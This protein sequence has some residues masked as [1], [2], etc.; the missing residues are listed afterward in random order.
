M[1]KISLKTLVQEELKKPAGKLTAG[2]QPIVQK[3]EEVKIVEN[4]NPK[5]RSGLKS[6]LEVNTDMQPTVKKNQLN[7]LV[8]TPVIQIQEQKE[9]IVIKVSEPVVEKVIVSKPVVEAAEIKIIKE[10]TLIDKASA[11]ISSR[12]KNEDSYQ[13]PVA[14]TPANFS[15]V[16]RKVK[17][18][19]E[20]I[21]KVSMSGP[22]SGEV[23]LLRLDDVNYQSWQNRDEHKILKFS[24]NANPAFD[25][26]TFG[27]LTGD[28]GEIF[29][30]KYNPYTGYTS[31]ANVAPGLTYY[32]PERDTLEVLHKDG[33]ATYVGQDNFIRFKNGNANTIQ[34]GSLVRF[35]GSDFV[36]NVPLCDLYVSDITSTPLYIT[37]VSVTDCEPDTLGRAMLLGE[38]EDFNASGSAVGEN[39][40]IGDLLWASPTVPGQLT[41]IR[42][43]SPNVVVSIAAVMNNSST[44][45][46]ILVRPTI[47]PR[48]LSGDFYSTQIQTAPNINFAHQITFSNTLFT[49]GVTRTGNVIT[50]SEAGLYK[51]DLRLQ[52]S[53]TNS[54][55]KSL[56]AWF[57]KDNVNVP[58]S[59]VRQSVAT[60]GGY[61]VLTNTQTISL[62][63]TDNVTMFYAVTSTSLFIDSPN[64]IDD[65]A[66]IPS[67]QLTVTQPAL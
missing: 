14:V 27:F 3:T 28:Q 43:T 13:Q 4:F 42:P 34:K 7:E 32:D 41:N 31:N 17:F 33:S 30:L 52:L 66:S 26:V 5:P 53:S 47:W 61:S 46:R 12:T 65:S 49:S 23:R 64:I 19:E 59:S 10:E 62:T 50:V 24:P 6:L 20:W 51:F 45:G 44:T 54:N 38:V 25:G 9:S 15:E 18:L 35:I 40:G 60:N 56:V 1:S 11:Y 29:S 37:G 63:P 57:K 36:S 21:G 2:W 8:Q 16:A 22:G 39:W 67:V 55:E 48:L 58:Y